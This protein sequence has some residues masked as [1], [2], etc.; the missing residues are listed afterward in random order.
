MREQMLSVKMPDVIKDYMNGLWKSDGSHCDLTQA[1]V[2]G[3]LLLGFLGSF[4]GS[5]RGRRK[6]A[7]RLTALSIAIIAM[8]AGTGAG[9]SKHKK[10]DAKFVQAPPT[11][12]LRSRLCLRN[13]AMKECSTNPRPV[14]TTTRLAAEP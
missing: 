2:P 3:W 9:C 13:A 6:S 7:S 14:V 10:T 5:P 12:A 1:G 11:C 8:A 4:L